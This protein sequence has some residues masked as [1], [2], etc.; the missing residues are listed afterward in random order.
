M[1]ASERLRE[2]A[3]ATEP[4]AELTDL[5]FVTPGQGVTTL[6]LIRHA[7]I[8]ATLSDHDHA[9][10][11]L[12]REQAEVLA[13]HLSNGKIAALYA[14]PTARARE[15]A[16][17]L[18]RVH[19]LD[20]QEVPDLRDV[21]H[22]KPMTKPLLEMLADEY[23]QD[24]APRVLARMQQE[25]TFDAMAPFFESGKSF[26]ARITR[27]I[28]DILAAHPGET[29]A[30][31]THGPVIMSF[32]AVIVGSPRDLPFYP[33]LTSITRIF[34]RDDRRT[35]DYLNARPHLEER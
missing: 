12:G 29:V 1:P 27:A 2:L 32:V 16:E 33:K 20:I 3:A 30:V 31:V 22:L 28:E 35:L 17:P 14:S 34:A 23:G 11:D 10:T 18:A 24:E 21:D 8:E 26:R 25:M 13:Q 4:R 15:T 7:Q 9:L 19:T 5:F 6:L